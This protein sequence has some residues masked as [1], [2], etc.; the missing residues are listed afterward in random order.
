M[1]DFL[2]KNKRKGIISLS[3][4]TGL[5]LLQVTPAFAYITFSDNVLIGGVNG[6]H[7]YVTKAT[8]SK[9]IAPIN[10]AMA[11]WQ[12]A[13]G[14][15]VSFTRTYDTYEVPSQATLRAKSYPN[16]PYTNVNGETEFYN[17]EIDMDSINPEYC[18]WQYT[19]IILNTYNIQNYSSDRIKGVVAHEMGHTLGLDENNS[20]PGSI[21]CQEASGRNVTQPQSDD[22]AGIKHLY[23]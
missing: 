2:K 9:Y 3:V 23:S 16:Y 4:L 1:K 11:D 6:R 10:N 17:K 15:L 20:N 12:S 22:V 8:D 5:M 7:Y 19:Q 18:N 13:T 14:N 21:M